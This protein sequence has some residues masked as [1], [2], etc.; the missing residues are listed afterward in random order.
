[1][2]SAE[3][4]L[5]TLYGE[6]APGYLPICTPEGGGF[7]TNWIP[8]TDLRQAAKVA[9]DKAKSKDVYFG[10]GLHSEGLGRSKRGKAEGVIAI[11]GFWADIDVR[12]E[13]HKNGNLPPSG[14]DALKILE[15]VPLKPTAVV[16]SGHG[17]Q[18]YWLFKELW[19]FEDDEERQ[20]A[21]D[22]SKRFQ[23]TLRAKANEY[24]WTLDGTHDISR[25]LRLPGTR[26]HKLE[27]VEVRVLQANED[28]RYNPGDLEP[29][30]IEVPEE[31]RHEVN[32]EA[33]GHDPE[34]AR[35]LL[36]LLR[37]R[38]SGRIRKAIEEGSRAYEPKPGGDGSTSGADAAVCTALIGAGLT[39]TQIRNVYKTY[40]IGTQG[41]YAERGDEYLV[42]TL[43]NEREWFKANGKAEG[44]SEGAWEEPAP[45]PE[46]L[47][48]VA[49]FDTEM[50]PAPLR[51]WIVDISERMQIP[52]DFPAA[53]AITVAS[54]LIGRKIGIR[55]K[56]YD[57]WLV[58]PNLWG[59]VVGKPAMLKSPALAEIMKPLSRL[60]AE[61]RDDYEA[62]LEDHKIR[63]AVAGAE[64]KALKDALEKAA[65]KARESGDRSEVE[66]IA[67]QQRDAGAPEEPVQRRYKTEDPTVEKLCELLIENPQGILVHRDELSGWLRSLDKQG[68]E[69][70]RSLYLE[71][72]NGDG[73]YE[74]DRIGRG[75]LYV[76]ALCVSILGGIQ[77]GPL[78]S[79]VREATRGAEGNDG[80]LQRFQLLV[81]PDAPKKW[82]NV[83][84]W[85]NSEAKKRAYEVFRKL[86]E[87]TAEG[88]GAMAEDEDS[89]PAVRFTPEAQREFDDWRA[90]LEGRLRSGELPPP[91]EAHLAKYRSLFPALALLFAAMEYVNNTGEGGAVGLEPTLA[92]WA[93]CGY[94]E[95]HARRLYSSAEDPAMEGARA[96][97][98]KIRTGEVRDGSTIREVY[99]GK[100]WS[101]LTNSEE[102]A[103]A[104]GVLEDYGWLRVETFK[105][106]GRP[107]Q[108]LR[109]H[110][111]L[112]GGT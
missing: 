50:L 18:V 107:T 16:H 81:W 65:K 71:S 38:L 7:V 25:V 22:L 32:F 63:V 28:R 86:D 4:F 59:S 79:Y 26:N 91:L 9:V 45:L 13:A 72:W 88:F 55:P 39:D 54:S 96:L 42:R 98:E 92:A 12:G 6:D 97:L 108:R 14:K 104:A 76:P 43:E 40:P 103:A 8:A 47:P 36:E 83:D 30:L 37:G 69:G 11:P 35:A 66:E 93:W 20:E 105:T 15:A 84:R 106:G 19:V 68:R 67:R 70:D 1:M 85:P 58:I 46:G 60:V 41:K 17:L 99:F 75:S 49:P 33:N 34:G 73:S 61:A 95:S 29:Y 111:S 110:P 112:R 82:H 89:I 100:H 21:R 3:S 101:R 57:D 80:L 2:R 90:E 51:N 10:L 94:L 5:A 77:P 74:V 102:A 23:A 48:P 62:A 31:E 52:P 53:G 109:L 78:S 44:Y 87:L 27:P 56:R 24:G 64:Q